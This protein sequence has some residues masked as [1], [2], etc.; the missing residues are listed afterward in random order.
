M[1]AWAM[2][3]FAAVYTGVAAGAMSWVKPR[4]KD[5]PLVRDAFGE[6]AVIGRH[7]HE[8]DDGLFDLP[9]Q[10][11]VARCVHEGAAVRTDVA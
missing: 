9:V 7:A 1:W 6:R 11:G 4:A 10:Q 8:V 5:D 2:P 3:P